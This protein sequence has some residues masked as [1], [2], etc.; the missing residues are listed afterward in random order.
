MTHD[1]HYERFG[2]FDHPF[3][4]NRLPAAQQ[5]VGPGMVQPCG[6][7][8]IAE[9]RKK[10]LE[11]VSLFALTCGAGKTLLMV[12]VLFAICHE[13]ASRMK[14]APRP[15]RVLWFSPNRALGIQLYGE[16]KD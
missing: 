13:I 16:L 6:D 3:D 7:I 10:L 8:F 1:P 9:K 12:S 14:H 4:L 11:H 15:H 2:Y 5:L